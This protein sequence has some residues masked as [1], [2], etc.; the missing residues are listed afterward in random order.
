MLRSLKI[1]AYFPPAETKKRGAVDSGTDGS[2][3]IWVD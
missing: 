3:A 1:M 2:E